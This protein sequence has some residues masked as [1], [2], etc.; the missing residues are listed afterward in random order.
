MTVALADWPSGG[1]NTWLGKWEKLHNDSVQ[2]DEPLRTWLRDVCQVWE[3]ISDLL[4]YISNIKLDIQRGNTAAHTPTSVSSTIQWHWQYRK[5]GLALR[6]SKP[7]TTRSAFATQKATPGDE[8]ETSTPAQSKANEKSKK[9]TSGKR[10]RTNDNFSAS[11][12][13]NVAAATSTSEASSK[14]TKQYHC[15]ACGGDRHTYD[16]CYFVLGEDGDKDWL[17]RGTFDNNMKVPSFK[18]KVESYRSA[19][20]TVAQ[21]KTEAKTD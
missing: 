3:Q 5:Q 11:P 4:V 6:V 17:D 8:D 13:S 14:R 2:Y 1:P 18:K 20:K 16:R 19:L 7:K 10:K 15:T 12:A 21:A 9:K